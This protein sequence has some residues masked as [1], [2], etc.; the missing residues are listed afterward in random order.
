MC[1]VRCMFAGCMFAGCA[2]SSRSALFLCGY[3]LAWA[4]LGRGWASGGLQLLVL[5][6]EG[7]H[8]GLMHVEQQE[9]QVLCVCV[10]ISL[11]TR[12]PHIP[13]PVVQHLHGFFEPYLSGCLDV[14]LWGVRSLCK[15][16]SCP[17]HF[18]GW[19]EL[20]AVVG[21][22]GCWQLNNWLVT[23]PNGCL[24]GVLSSRRL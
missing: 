13:R 11:R 19:Q 12:G 8:H 17:N 9:L 6:Q 7:A 1:S 14:G 3:Q 22:G 24:Q 21:S 10:C 4:A 16:V 15:L 2:H 18:T 20:R 5:Q 23:G